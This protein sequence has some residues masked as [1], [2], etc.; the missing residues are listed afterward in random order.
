MLLHIYI[1]IGVV[2][3]MYKSVEFLCKEDG[4]SNRSSL[5]SLV[6][7][8]IS[9][10]LLVTLFWGPFLLLKIPFIKRILQ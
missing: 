8:M 2:L 9:L 5:V 1:I 4:F 3:G 10:L 6:A 7:T